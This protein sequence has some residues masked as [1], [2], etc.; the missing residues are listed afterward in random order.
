M[1]MVIHQIPHHATHPAKELRLGLS[2]LLKTDGDEL[3]FSL[4]ECLALVDDLLPEY[5]DDLDRIRT[6]R[7]EQT[8]KP[9]YLP[10]DVD[11][12]YGQ[13]SVYDVCRSNRKVPSVRQNIPGKTAAECGMIIQNN[14]IVYRNA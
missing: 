10:D 3:D 1:F 9:R 7:S 6:V 13:K 11:A 4:F 5:E 12:R 14:N 2:R 8:G